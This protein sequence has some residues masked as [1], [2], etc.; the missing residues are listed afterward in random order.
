LPPAGSFYAHFASK[1]DLVATVVAHELSA[2]IAGYGTLRPGRPGIEDFIREYLSPEHRDNPGAGCPSAALLDE[3]GRCGEGTKQAYTD[4]TRIIVEEV[5][6]R[7]A[8]EDPQSARGKAIG[9]F[10]MMVGTLQLSRALS[11]RKFA[12]EVLERGIESGLSFM[13]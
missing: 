7:L 10:T 6:A 1:D 2:Q 11:D 9:L 12:D 5:A 13:R 8:P 4:G 3:I